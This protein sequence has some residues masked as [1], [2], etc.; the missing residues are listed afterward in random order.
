MTLEKQEWLTVKEIAEYLE[1]N[2]QTVARLINEG[3]L[4]GRKIGGRFKVSKEELLSF[5]GKKG[6]VDA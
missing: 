2:R 6:D 1:I 3:K 5:I 4:P